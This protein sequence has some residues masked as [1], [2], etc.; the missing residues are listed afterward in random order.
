M[1]AAVMSY[2]AI[3][4]AR[5]EALHQLNVSV[6]ETQREVQLVRAAVSREDVNAHGCGAP[7]PSESLRVFHQRAAH[8]SL[9]IRREHQQIADIRAI[10]LLLIR[11]LGGHCSED[12]DESSHVSVDLRHEDR[13]VVTPA[14]LEEKIEVGIGH[15]AAVRQVRLQRTFRIL[16]RSNA[17]KELRSIASR[18]A[19]SNHAS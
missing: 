12:R 15:V 6:L 1:Q 13:T 11:L 18:V 19:R 7:T 10:P 2:G 3:S 5:A 16:E 17:D 9:S 8:S 4:G 14:T